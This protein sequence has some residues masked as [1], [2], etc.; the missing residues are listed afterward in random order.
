MTMSTSS[1]CSKTLAGTASSPFQ[2][3]SASTA[4]LVVPIPR[5][6]PC[7]S[8]FSG[9]IIP[10]CLHLLFIFEPV[11]TRIGRRDQ[12]MAAGPQCYRQE[13]ASGALSA[14]PDSDSTVG[15]KEKGGKL[16]RILYPR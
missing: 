14:L 1:S 16:G 11:Q 12:G 3:V 13:P 6:P 2:C 5:R 4:I 9:R 7:P 10:P 8:P 15:I